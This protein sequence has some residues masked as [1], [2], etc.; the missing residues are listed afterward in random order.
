M[1]SLDGDNTLSIKIPSM[2]GTADTSYVVNVKV[3]IEV[4]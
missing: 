2:T 3:E 4:D 1:D